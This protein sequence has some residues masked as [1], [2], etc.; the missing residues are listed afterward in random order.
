VVYLP[1]MAA[2]QPNRYNVFKAP[3]HYAAIQ[4][5]RDAYQNGKAAD[6]FKRYLLDVAPQSDNRPF[7]GRLLKWTQIRHYY[8]T[9]GSR[10]YTLLLSGEVIVVVVL[11]EAIVVSTAILILPLFLLGESKATLAWPDLLFFLNVGFGFMLVELFFINAYTLFF[12]EAAVSLTV[13][14]AGILISSSIGG[15]F[16]Q[17]LTGRQLR[18]GIILLI[19]LLAVLW[20][21]LDQWRVWCLTVPD[22]GRHLLALGLLFPVGCL[23]GLPF[24]LGMRL[25]LSAPTQRAHAWAI[26]GCASVVTSVAAM[27]L[28]ISFGLPALLHGAILT[29]AVAFLALGLRK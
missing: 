8:Q 12:N 2:Q 29:Y 13:V 27:Q 18:H 26:N 21:T 4:K 9:M 7:P 16:S 22:W 10:F 15:Y 1:V 6:F 17:R 3:F 20:L 28:A 23:L 25:L 11:I 14:L 19:L 5:L 24:P